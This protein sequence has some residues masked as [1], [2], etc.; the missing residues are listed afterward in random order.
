MACRIVCRTVCRTVCMLVGTGHRTALRSNGRPPCQYTRRMGPPAWPSSITPHHGMVCNN[1]RRCSMSS[2]LAYTVALHLSVHRGPAPACIGPL[3]LVTHQKTKTHYPEAIMNVA[4]NFS[5]P[6]SSDFSMPAWNL[7]PGAGAS[8]HVYNNG[9]PPGASGYAPSRPVKP[10]STVPFKRD[11]NLVKRPA[12]S[13]W[14]RDQTT[15]LGSRAALVGLGGVG[16]DIIL[17]VPHPGYVLRPT[18]SSQEIANCDSTRAPSPGRVTRDLGLLGLC[19]LSDP[20]QR[21]VPRHSRQAT[22]AWAGRS[23]SQHPPARV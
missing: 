10:F 7:Q 16:Y 2:E 15:E 13:Q 12:I 18:D 4:N 1:I 20:V 22:A 21:G 14:L 11:P 8:F 17:L 5:A 19:Q 9:P 3:L 23:R 6:V